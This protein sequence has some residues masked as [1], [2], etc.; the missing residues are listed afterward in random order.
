MLFIEI[1]F[2]FN[3]IWYT[4]IVSFYNLTEHFIIFNKTKIEKTLLLPNLNQKREIIIYFKT[5][6][7]FGLKEIHKLSHGKM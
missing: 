3:E 6:L 2:T 7:I 4:C 1:N 5:L